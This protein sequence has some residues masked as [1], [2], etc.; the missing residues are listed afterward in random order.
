MKLRFLEKRDEA[1][2]IKSFFWKPTKFFSF[3]PGQYL[4]YTLS[5]LKYR[6]PRGAILDFTI[7]NSPTEKLIQLTTRIR[8]SG[9]KKTLDELPIGSI[10]EASG[11]NGS[12]CLDV[13]LSS[14]QVFIAGG[15]GITPFRSM[16]KYDIDKKLK[17]PIYL[18]YSNSDENFIFKNE[19]DEWQKENDFIKIYYHNSSVSGRIDKLKIDELIGNGSLE[20]D[21]SVFYV[22]GPPLFVS[23]MENILEKMRI[24]DDQIKTD[25]FT[26]Y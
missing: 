26:G 17:I 25:K 21:N 1:P 22:A 13:N 23:A 2:G 24:P 18:I 3:E 8:E 10:V 7:A 20:I 16:I 14:C 6:D 15:I 5:K 11:P 19:F 4:Y 12:F 9:F